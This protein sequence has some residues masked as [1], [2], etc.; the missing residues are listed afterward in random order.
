VQNKWNAN[1]AEEIKKLEVLVGAF[2]IVASLCFV[3]AVEHR[4]RQ[5]S[6]VGGTPTGDNLKCTRFSSSSGYPF[7]REN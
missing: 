2:Q 5:A 1:V 7:E 4:P 3:W 6:P